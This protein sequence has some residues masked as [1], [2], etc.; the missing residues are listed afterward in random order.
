MHTY[1][2]N[3]VC[4]AD[5]H[6]VRVGADQQLLGVKQY[7][8]IVADD[9]NKLPIIEK[10]LLQLCYSQCIIFVNDRQKWVFSLRGYI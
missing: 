7:V 5:M 1:S 10:L 2:C 6:V 8:V 9:H 3:N 4:N